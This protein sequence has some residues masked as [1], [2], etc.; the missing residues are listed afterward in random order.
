MRN[1]ITVNCAETNYFKLASPSFFFL[2]QLGKTFSIVLQDYFLPLVDQE[3]SPSPIIFTICYFQTVFISARHFSLHFLFKQGPI[4]FR[5]T[6]D[7]SQNPRRFYNLFWLVGLF[8][9]RRFGIPHSVTTCGADILTISGSEHYWARTN[10]SQ[11][12]LMC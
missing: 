10:S 11:Q 6:M 5:A 1:I 8:T 12:R 3:L 2:A 7:F 4:R 9:C